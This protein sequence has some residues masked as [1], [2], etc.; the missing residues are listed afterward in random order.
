MSA[1]GQ[2]TLLSNQQD[3]EF[4][5]RGPKPQLPR[6]QARF[7]ERSWGNGSVSERDE[8]SA[9]AKRIALGSRLATIDGEEAH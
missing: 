1:F 4:L 5:P 8:K 9:T 7:R 2:R 3:P 6:D